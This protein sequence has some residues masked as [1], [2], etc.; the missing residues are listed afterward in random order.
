MNNLLHNKSIN[1]TKNLWEH[2]LS[3]SEVTPIQ[4]ANLRKTLVFYGLRITTEQ[5]FI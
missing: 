5:F 4:W 3:L 1:L 2:M